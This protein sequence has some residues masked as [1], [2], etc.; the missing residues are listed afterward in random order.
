MRRRARFLPDLTPPQVI[1]H[2][3]VYDVTKYLDEH[4]GGEEVLLEVSGDSEDASGAFD[5]IGHSSDAKAVR[6]G[7]RFVHGA[8]V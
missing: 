2:G 4:P 7:V 6:G 8:A 1:I 5:D 3:D